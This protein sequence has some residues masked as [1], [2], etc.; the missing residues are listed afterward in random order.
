MRAIALTV[1][2]GTM[3]SLGS[4]CCSY[5]VYQNSRQEVQERAF[6][7]QAL[8][9]GG[10][11]IGI[12]LLSLDALTEHPFLQF[13]AAAADAATVYGISQAT[14]PQGHGGHEKS[15][16]INVQGNGNNTTVIQGQG[17]TG[18]GSQDNSE[19]SAP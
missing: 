19:R 5:L 6:R 10:A 1:L 9:G 16:T 3:L 11:G 4:G 13:F 2:I 14:A 15:T 7:A 17:N 18:N 8:E 12:D